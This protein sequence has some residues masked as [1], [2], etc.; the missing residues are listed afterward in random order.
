VSFHDPRGEVEKVREL[1][2]S[3]EKP[4]A[5]L[6]G[7]GA[8]CAPR[9][10]NG[11]RLDPTLVPAVLKLGE[12]CSKEIVNLGQQYEAIYNSLTALIRSRRE[13]LKR[14][15][16]IEAILSAV[17]LAIASMGPDDTVGG[18]TKAELEEIEGVIRQCIAAA[19]LPDEARIPTNLPHHSLA[20]WIGRIPRRTPVELFTTNYD[21]LLERALEDEHIPFY[22]G[23]AGGRRPFFLGATPAH[24]FEP[25]AGWARLWKI[26]GSVTWWWESL[27]GGGRRVTRGAENRNGELILPS[28]HKYDESRRQPYASMIDRF[29][30]VLT[31]REDTLLVTIGFSFND[32]HLNAVVFDALATHT[33]LSVIVLQHSEPA[34]DHELRKR[35]V[36][37]PNLLLYGPLQATVGG[38][39]APWRL[40]EPVDERTT[41]LLDIPFDSDAMPEGDEVADTGRFRLGDFYWFGRFLDRITGA[42]D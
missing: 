40:G 5:F 4:I 38:V 36:R 20:R 17:R 14:P 31:A 8:S 1:L 37:Y 35:A 6:I 11:K 15:V 12:L 19:A 41:D 42:D 25:G 9:D 18:G 7:A 23:F 3:H 30:R 21:T 26:H 28:A 34:K 33:K 39:T 13:P 10:D 2:A 27:P 16:D 24:D 22:D 29:A 32:E